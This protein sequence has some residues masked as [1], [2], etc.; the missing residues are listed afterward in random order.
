MITDRDE[1]AQAAIRGMMPLIDTKIIDKDFVNPIAYRIA[2]EILRSQEKKSWQAETLDN[3]IVLECP[4]RSEHNCNAWKHGI[5]IYEHTSGQFYRKAHCDNCGWTWDLKDETPYENK[6]V[7]IKAGTS[8]L[9]EDQPSCCRAVDE[10]R[11]WSCEHK[12]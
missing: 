12:P 10:G 4:K 1:L 11:V 7:P 9:I 6:T 3:L 8:V 2:D 5:T